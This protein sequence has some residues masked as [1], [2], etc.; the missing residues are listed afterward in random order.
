[1]TNH[2]DQSGATALDPVCGMTVTPAGAAGHAEHRGRVYY[3][4]GTGCLK[5]F[6]ANPGAY[7]SDAVDAPRPTGPGV[8]P[9][10]EYTCPMHPEIRQK[11][12][13]SCPL[14]GMAL[15]PV[16]VSLEDEP[17]EELEDMTRR[18]RW[19]LVLTLPILAVMVS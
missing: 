9:A 7:V 15:E 14:C 1:M 10:G 5:K 4:C 3:F 16:T 6:Q 18:L 2:L 11:G 17:N 8:D 19:G 13:G 12:P